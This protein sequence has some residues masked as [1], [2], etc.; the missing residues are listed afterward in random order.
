[1]SAYISDFK[2]NFKCGPVRAVDI[3]QVMC[4]ALGIQP[5]PH[6]GT[7]SSVKDIFIH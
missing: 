1:L 7:W 6:K 5:L 2:K 3:Y 4:K